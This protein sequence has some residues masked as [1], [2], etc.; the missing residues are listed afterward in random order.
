MDFLPGARGSFVALSERAKNNSKL[1]NPPSP[2]LLLS[3]INCF[4]FLV[5][6]I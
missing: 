4:F 6:T 5:F 3:G 2:L 1:L